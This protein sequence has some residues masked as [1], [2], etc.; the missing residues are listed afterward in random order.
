MCRMSVLQIMW[1][2]KNIAKAEFDKTSLLCR[3]ILFSCILKKGITY[4]NITNTRKICL[5]ETMING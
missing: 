5:K 4:D 1:K 3:V 2:I